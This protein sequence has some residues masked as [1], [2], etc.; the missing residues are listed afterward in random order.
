MKNLGQVTIFVCFWLIPAIGGAAQPQP[1]SLSLRMA[2]TGT[3]EKDANPYASLGGTLEYGFFRSY[4]MGAEY[5]YF[6]PF[7]QFDDYVYNGMNDAAV[8]LGDDKL[9]SNIYQ[10]INVAVKF[11]FLMPTSSDSRAANIRYGLSQNLVVR[12]GFGGRFS[13]SYSLTA[14]EYDVRS[15]IAD[16]SGETPIYNTRFDIANKITAVYDLLRSLHCQFAV[17]ARTYNDYADATYNIYSLGTGIGYD[18]DKNSS[19]DFGVRTSQKSANT[20]E[21]WNGPAVSEHFFDAAGTVVYLG[22]TIKI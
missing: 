1:V 20:N 6:H 4:V 11:S 22:S 21:T 5:S 12:K 2:G 19:L 7:T 13:T 10:N 18:I 16:S 17:S 15:T 9:W 8:Y 14:N 3:I